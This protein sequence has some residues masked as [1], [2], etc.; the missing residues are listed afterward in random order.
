MKLGHCYIS[1]VIE[2]NPY[3]AIKGYE[4]CERNVSYQIIENGAHFFSKKHDRIAMGYLEEFV[5]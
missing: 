2:M 4:G 5:N 3:E 1:D